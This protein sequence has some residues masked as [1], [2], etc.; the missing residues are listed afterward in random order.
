[1]PAGN[2]SL[3]SETFYGTHQ[4]VKFFIFT[5]SAARRIILILSGSIQIGM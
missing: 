2:F 4:L 3:E 5:G 1:M